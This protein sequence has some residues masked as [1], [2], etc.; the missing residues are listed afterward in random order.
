MIEKRIKENFESLYAQ[1]FALTEMMDRL[2]PGNSAR[3]FTTASTREL[4]LQ[5][6]SFFAEPAGASRFQ[7]IAPLTA[8]GYSPDT[9][10]DSFP[11]SWQMKSCF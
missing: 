3:E 8:A 6:E 4:R 10:L 11:L 7:P 1:I 5:S 9:G 2:I